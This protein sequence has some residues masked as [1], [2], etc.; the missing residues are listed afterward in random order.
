MPL[1]CLYLVFIL[2]EFGVA[3]FSVQR[4][5]VTLVRHEQP[6]GFFSGLGGHCAPTLEAKLTTTTQLF[7]LL[8][9][10]W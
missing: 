9:Q 3:I 10:R 4:R 2:L 1:S 7:S 8:K 5:S 6:R